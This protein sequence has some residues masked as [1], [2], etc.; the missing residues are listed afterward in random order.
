MNC[1]WSIQFRHTHENYSHMD[2]C[3]DNNGS[4]SVSKMRRKFTTWWDFW[5]ISDAVLLKTK[6]RLKRKKTFHSR[7]FPTSIQLQ[8]SLIKIRRRNT[9]CSLESCFW[10]RPTSEE[11]DSI[12]A[13]FFFI[14]ST[15]NVFIFKSL[16]RVFILLFICAVILLLSSSIK[17]VK[18]PF[19][20]HDVSS[21]YC[22]SFCCYLF[23]KK[24]RFRKWFAKRHWRTCKRE[25]EEIFTG[26][27]L[28]NHKF[29]KC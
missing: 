24:Q 29:M 23:K 5:K 17:A 18:W 27:S 4:Q 13:G 7:L 9:H 15:E 8:Q 1:F 3:G 25:E 6:K 11:H 20:M 14:I 22:R 10:R 12:I 16:W 28:R 2:P 19:Y 21:V 26:D